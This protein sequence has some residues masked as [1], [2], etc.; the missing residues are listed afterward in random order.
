MASVI[1]QFSPYSWCLA[2]TNFHS[3]HQPGR[4]HM[5]HRLAADATS[6]FWYFCPPIRPISLV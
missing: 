3:Q 2:E 4:G 1:H 5:W 6:R